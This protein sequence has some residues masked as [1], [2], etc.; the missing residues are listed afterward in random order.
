MQER[1]LGKNWPG[2]LCI[3]H[4]T[5]PKFFAYIV[6]RLFLAFVLQSNPMTKAF[7]SSGSFAGTFS[8]EG[9]GSYPGTSCPPIR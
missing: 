6:R 5:S 7:F 1:P 4:K 2:A 9:A 3:L 8:S